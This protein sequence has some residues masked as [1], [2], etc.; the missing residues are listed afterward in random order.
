MA[1]VTLNSANKG[2]CGHTR[3]LFCTYTLISGSVKVELGKHDKVSLQHCF[4]RSANVHVLWT[5][6]PGTGQSCVVVC[7]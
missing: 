2:E 3:L 6:Q 5:S 1:T 7:V 4:F